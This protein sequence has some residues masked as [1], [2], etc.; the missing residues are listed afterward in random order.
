MDRHHALLIWRDAQEVSRFPLKSLPFI[1]AGSIPRN[2][3]SK[4][5]FQ[6]YLEAGGDGCKLVVCCLWV[7]NEVVPAGEHFPAENEVVIVP[8]CCAFVGIACHPA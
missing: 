8:V 6:V 5:K 1:G 3:Q 4:V 7:A 2:K